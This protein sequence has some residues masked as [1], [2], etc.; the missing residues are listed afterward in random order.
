ML[1][2]AFCKALELRIDELTLQ[3]SGL[4]RVVNSGKAE[5]FAQIS[6]RCELKHD[7]LFDE[8]TDEQLAQ[9]DEELRQ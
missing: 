4:Y 5:T 6:N 1:L 9:D 3:L 7:S 8:Q 2:K